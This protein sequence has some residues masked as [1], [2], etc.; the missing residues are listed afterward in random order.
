MVTGF[1]FLFPASLCLY[2]LP[3]CSMLINASVALTP[4]PFSLPEHLRLELKLLSQ[5][6]VFGRVFSLGVLLPERPAVS[7]QPGKHGAG[8]G[9]VGDHSR[10]SRS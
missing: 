2:L 1:L 8:L 9:S 3:V 10:R 4:P 6:L 5:L 7:Q